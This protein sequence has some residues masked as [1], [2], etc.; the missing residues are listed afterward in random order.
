MIRCLLVVLLVASSFVG[1]GGEDETPTLSFDGETATYSGPEVLS[2]MPVAFL[3]E[4]PTTGMVIFGWS[5]TNDESIT[6]EDEVAWIESHGDELPPWAEEEYGH[7]GVNFM[8]DTR[9]E[10]VELP[11]G[12]VFLWAN[13]QS[14]DAVYPAAYVTVDT[15]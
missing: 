1:C 12:H 6:L 3:L 11:D 14:D 13:T 4:N 7:L 5:V 15:G 9:E 10:A 2:E 8:N